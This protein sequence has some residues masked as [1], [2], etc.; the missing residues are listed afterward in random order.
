MTLR[1]RI[2]VEAYTGYCMTSGEERNAFNKYIAE[3]MGRPIYTHE[4]A[5]NKIQCELHDK[6]KTDFIKLCKG[7]E[8]EVM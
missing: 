7:N 4:L 6:A 3:V 5:D 8:S 2:I 1:E